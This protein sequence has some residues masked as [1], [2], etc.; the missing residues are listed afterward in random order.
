[1]LCTTMDHCTLHKQIMVN[2]CIFSLM[3]WLMLR[4]IQSQQDNIC[5]ISVPSSG[6][7]EKSEKQSLRCQSKSPVADYS[8]RPPASNPYRHALFMA[9]LS[10]G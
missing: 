2:F 8:I 6:F 7:A 5:V 1:M 10:S 3:V 4:T 9:N